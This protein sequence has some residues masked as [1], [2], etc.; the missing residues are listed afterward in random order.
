MKDFFFTFGQTHFTLDGI[1]MKDYY[2]GVTAHGRQE[3]RD[4][5]CRNFVTPMMGDAGKWAFQYDADKFRPEYFP[6][7]EF[8]HLTVWDRS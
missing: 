1:P 2:V 7:G 6:A 8:R 5:F 3:A 4:F